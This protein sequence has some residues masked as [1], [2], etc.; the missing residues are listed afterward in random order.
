MIAF[1]STSTH[2]GPEIL[3]PGPLVLVRYD[4]AT[5]VKV[6]ASSAH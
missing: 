3:W 6:A 4:T 2:H 1:H 5:P